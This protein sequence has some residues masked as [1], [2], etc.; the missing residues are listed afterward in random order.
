M[1][2]LLRPEGSPL[3]LVS[4]A[5]S[6]LTGLAAGL[7]DLQPSSSP[8]GFLLESPPKSLGGLSSLRRKP[9]SS[10]RKPSLRGPSRSSIL[11]P[12]SLGPSRGL[13]FRSKS[14]GPS[15]LR[16]HRPPS[17]PPSLGSSKRPRWPGRS[18]EKSLLD[19]SLCFLKPSGSFPLPGSL[20]RPM[21]LLGRLPP[22]PSSLGRSIILDGSC[23]LILSCLCCSCLSSSSCLLASSAC[24]CSSLF[25][26]AS[27]LACIDL[28]F[29]YL[30]FSSLYCR[31]LSLIWFL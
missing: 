2:R 19:G 23:C 25:L 12:K 24:L 6:G 20:S 15:S 29:S 26:L 11:L 10:L 3:L 13:L 21:N 7:L 27:S 28:K 17:R 31:I 14:L 22:G 18:P 9:S 4:L 1:K 8:E 5:L 30:I 16:P